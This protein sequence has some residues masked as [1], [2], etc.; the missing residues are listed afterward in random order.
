VKKV[1]AALRGG[2]EPSVT[3]QAS[4]GDAIRREKETFRPALLD[5]VKARGPVHRDVA[6]DVLDDHVYRPEDVE[7]VLSEHLYA[8]TQDGTLALKDDFIWPAQMSVP[9]VRR[10]EGREPMELD[11]VPL[12]EIGEAELYNMGGNGEIGRSAL[13]ERTAAFYR[14]DRL[15]DR[16][17]SRLELA[18]EKLIESGRLAPRGKDLLRR[19]R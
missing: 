7:K 6:K 3:P 4:A 9:P 11:L 17:R 19:A 1:L 15:P 12:E 14:H 18:L 13:I 10:P 16:T 5:L 2:S 8:L